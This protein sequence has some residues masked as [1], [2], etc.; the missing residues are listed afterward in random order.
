MF[1][2]NNM[3]TTKIRHLIDGDLTYVSE[4]RDKHNRV[5]LYFKGGSNVFK[6]SSENYIKA[7]MYTI[8]G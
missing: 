4:T 6:E 3:D 8:N 7:L 5:I 2:I 1:Q